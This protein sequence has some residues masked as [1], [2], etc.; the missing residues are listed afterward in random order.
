MNPPHIPRDP[1]PS[2]AMVLITLLIA[3]GACLGTVLLGIRVVE[4]WRGQV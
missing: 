4:W 1:P 2:I 3:V